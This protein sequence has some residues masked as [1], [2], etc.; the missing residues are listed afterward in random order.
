MATGTAHEVSL[1]D[2]AWP[3]RVPVVCVLEVEVD[4]ELIVVSPVPLPLPLAL[5]LPL[6]LP[7]YWG[8]VE[9]AVDAS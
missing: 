1:V 2:G 5:P 3:L 4:V 6:P 8:I 9:G 7:M